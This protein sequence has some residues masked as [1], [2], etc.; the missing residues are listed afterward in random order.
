MS[1]STTPDGPPPMSYE[2]ARDQ[3]I[4][5]V[6]QLESGGQALEESIALWERGEKLADICQIWLDG[7]KARLDAA[8]PPDDEAR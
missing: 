4:E 6:K 5:V 8:A 1:E 3:L 7:A 2:E